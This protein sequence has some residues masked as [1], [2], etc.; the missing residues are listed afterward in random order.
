MVSGEKNALIIIEEEEEQKTPLR[1]VPERKRRKERE[2]AEEDD[3]GK[4]YS[5]RTK[6]ESDNGDKE[7]PFVQ[8]KKRSNPLSLSLSMRCAFF[9]LFFSLLL[10]FRDHRSL[11]RLLITV[12]EYFVFFNKRGHRMMCC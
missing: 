5:A 3:D 9:F 12:M 7:E 11:D 1:V 6:R 2:I 4:R 8:K 10:V